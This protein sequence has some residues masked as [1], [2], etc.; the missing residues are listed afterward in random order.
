MI[1]SVFLLF[2]LTFLFI[3]CHVDEQSPL[4]GTGELALSMQLEL[5][6]NGR[7]A[8]V[9][10][11]EETGTIVYE[12]APCLNGDCDDLGTEETY[13]V[14]AY[15]YADGSISSEKL[16][17]PVG[18]YVITSCALLNSMKDV[19]GY[20]PVEGNIPD[21]Y[22]PANACP[23]A[24]EITPNSIVPVEVHFVLTSTSG[25]DLTDIGY[26]HLDGDIGD[27]ERLFLEI[28]RMV[29]VNGVQSGQ[30]LNKAYT[31]AL[32]VSNSGVNLISDYPVKYGLA[33]MILPLNYVGESLDVSVVFP[34]V[35]ATTV[36][37]TFVYQKDSDPNS[38]AIGALV[39]SQTTDLTTDFKT[40]YS[41]TNFQPDDWYM[42]LINPYDLIVA[43]P[44]DCPSDWVKG[45]AYSRGDLVSAA[46]IG[47]TYTWICLVSHTSVNADEPSMSYQSNKD[48]YTVQHHDKWMLLGICQGSSWPSLKTWAVTGG[49]NNTA[50]KQDELVQYEGNVYQSIIEITGNY[51]SDAALHAP[52]KTPL[53]SYIGPY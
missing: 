24:F 25:G 27:Y 40:T 45:T 30:Y 16:L 13:V 49:G 8:A 50:Y 21:G 18:N 42:T 33:V 31:G 38:E 10:M 53:W 37:D 52:D 1:R 6:E 9:A 23:I 3:S 14:E 41:I 51:A 47:V 44:Q 5:F 22:D 48:I 12:V 39:T 36:D 34:P 32:S 7:Q 2:S 43:P 28:A 46:S 35:T 19:I 20:V 29:P 15:I 4:N 11:V 17:L 26:G